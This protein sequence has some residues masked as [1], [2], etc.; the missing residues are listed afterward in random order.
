VVMQTA[1]MWDGDDR[2]ARWR[3][4][5]S[6]DGRILVQREVS[7]PC[8]IVGEVALQVMV[9]RALVPHDD[10]IEALA[11]EGADHAFN[12][13]ILPGTTR[14]CHHIFDAHL[15]HGPPSIRSL[16]RIDPG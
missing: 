15:L 5:S 12:E 7:E 11:P 2:A 9:Q 6:R 14:R 13:R 10:V 1:E 16:N 4:G 8:V 3:L